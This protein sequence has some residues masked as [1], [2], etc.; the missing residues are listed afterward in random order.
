LDVVDK[1]LARWLER[2]KVII[3]AI[4]ISILM[5]LMPFKEG[6]LSALRLVGPV[7]ALRRKDKMIT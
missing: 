5:L 7:K 6:W 3:L 1:E 2:T 4:I